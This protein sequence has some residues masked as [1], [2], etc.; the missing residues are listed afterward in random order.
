MVEGNSREYGLVLVIFSILASLI[1][2][3][4][5]KTIYENRRLKE[6]LNDN[7]LFERNIDTLNEKIN[8]YINIDE[9]IENKK[10]E[11]FNSNRKLE[12][13]ILEGKS[14]AKIAYLTFDDGPYQLT[15]QVLDILKEN[16]V[17]ATFFVLGKDAEDRY[18]RIVNEGHTLANHTYYH[19]IGKGL[20][21]S[22]ESFMSQ[23][24]QLEDYLYNITGYKTNLVRFPGGSETANTYHVRDSII[25]QLHNKGYKY[26]DWTCE[27]G[28][29]SGKRLQQKSEWEWYKDTCKDQKIMVLLMHDYHEGTVKI[30]PEI[31]NDL[32]SQGYLILPLSNKSVMVK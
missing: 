12:D 3:L 16:D 10:E 11:Y 25:E 19:N 13:Q 22:P 15:N 23:V 30:L 28:D 5:L 1:I 20:Y 18:K 9:T 14:D 32:K 6:E 17:K 4:D 7:L 31:I 2:C 8:E 21:R 24:N 26:V 27:T 29:G